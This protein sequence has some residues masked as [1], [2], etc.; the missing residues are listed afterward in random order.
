VQELPDTQRLVILHALGV[1]IVV[2]TL[3]LHI[4]IMQTEGQHVHDIEVIHLIATHLLH[5]MKK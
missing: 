1:G 2:T 5:T 3:R 4:D